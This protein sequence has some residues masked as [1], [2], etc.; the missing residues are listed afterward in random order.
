MSAAAMAVPK[1]WE[2]SG[3]TKTPR[4]FFKKLFR[5]FSQVELGVLGNILDDSV[6]RRG[7]ADWVEV[8]EPELARLVNCHVNSVGAALDKLEALSAIEARKSPRDKRVKQYRVLIHNWAKITEREARKLDRKGP[9]TAGA[10]EVEAA[11]VDAAVDDRPPKAALTVIQAKV[12]MVTLPGAKQPVPLAE[13]CPHGS[14]CELVQRYAKGA[15]NARRRPSDP[16]RLNGEI[17]TVDCGDSRPALNGDFHRFQRFVAQALTKRLNAPPPGGLIE[18]LYRRLEQERVPF[19]TF[20][21]RFGLRERAVRSYGFL[22][23]IVDDCV[24]AVNQSRQMVGDAKRTPAAVVERVQRE[25]KRAAAALRNRGGCDEAVKLL[26]E[27]VKIAATLASDPERLQLHLMNLDDLLVTAAEEKLSQSELAQAD[28]EATADWPN[29]AVM[30]QFARERAVRLM[31]VGSEG[32]A[33][34]GAAR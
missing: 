32:M 28:A 18:E 14:Q 13:A 21:L 10:V 8:R 7:E 20:V 24:A 29:H 9:G 15:A 11:E 22:R 33:S 26:E 1:N 23:C 34:A 27:T 5:V 3:W 6:G 30:R 19:E 25:A 17:T 12:P 2:S 16:P 31:L 4:A